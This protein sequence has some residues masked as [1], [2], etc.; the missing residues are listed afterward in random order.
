MGSE[1][2]TPNDLTKVKMVNKNWIDLKKVYIMTYYAQR[3]YPCYSGYWRHET[4]LFIKFLHRSDP[5]ERDLKANSELYFDEPMNES[6]NNGFYDI[7][8]KVE[9]D[10][11]ELYLSKIRRRK[12]RKRQDSNLFFDNFMI[13]VLVKIEE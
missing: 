7:V 9:E 11:Y 2:N 4:H 12:K 5:V 10:E 1:F 6:H 3:Y 8:V 13:N